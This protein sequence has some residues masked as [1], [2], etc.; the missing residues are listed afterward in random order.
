MTK[1][2]TINAL[3]AYEQ[4]YWEYEKSY[5]RCRTLSNRIKEYKK[6]Y[7]EKERVK[8]SVIGVL[9]QLFLVFYFSMF[10][11]QEIDILDQ[12]QVLAF[13][14]SAIVTAASFVV[15][16]AIVRRENNKIIAE[17]AKR[18]SEWARRQQSLPELN[19]QLSDETARMEKLK[20]RAHW[21]GNFC[22][23]RGDYLNP[24]VVNR[25]VKYLETGRCDSLKEALN[26]YE[27]EKRE[28]L[29]DKEA[30]QHR[31]QM[32][33]YAAAS[34]EASIAAARNSEEAAFWAATSAFA[35]FTAASNS[36]KANNSGEYHVV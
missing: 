29:R 33:N 32:E 35:S 19:K 13:L 36:S 21:Q 30:R 8:R 6:P 5:Q 3:T 17:N 1:E 10:I 23:L 24:Y 31:R 11:L 25:L 22:G 34:A 18:H 2:E 12:R 9:S 20:Q 27:V 15:S 4:K 16:G 28:E 14:I 26:L 7:W